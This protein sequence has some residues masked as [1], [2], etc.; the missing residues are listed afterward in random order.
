MVLSLS[1]IMHGLSPLRLI[2]PIFDKELRVSSRR[3]RN[4]VLRS[5]GLSSATGQLGLVH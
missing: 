1:G 2:G 5:A 4:Y 3:Q